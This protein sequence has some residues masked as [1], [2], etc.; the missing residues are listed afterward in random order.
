MI[1]HVAWLV[2][3]YVDTLGDNGVL[4]DVRITTLACRQLVPVLKQAAGQGAGHRKY[5][6]A[7]HGSV[8]GFVC[9]LILASSV[10]KCSKS[11]IF[12]LVNHAIKYDNAL[13]TANAYAMQV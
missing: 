8:R 9:C 6:C 4:S 5:S 7:S 13:E 3:L 11:L 10:C 1:Y 2:L 12:P